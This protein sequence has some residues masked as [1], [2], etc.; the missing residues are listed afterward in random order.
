MDVNMDLVV[1][2]GSE[3]LDLSQLELEFKTTA[4]SQGSPNTALI[5]IYNPSPN[6]INKIQK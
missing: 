3:A 2:N 5:R 1:G 6:T 4:A